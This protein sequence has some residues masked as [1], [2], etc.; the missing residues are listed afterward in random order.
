VRAVNLI[1]A[2]ERRG[3]G[4]LAGRSGGVV[5][6]VPGG[7]ALVVALGVVYA[8]AVHTVA[9]RTGELAAVNQQVAAVNAETA[10]LQ[11][12][13]QIASL[14]EQKL[15]QVATLAQQ[16]FNWP[17][18]MEQL[19]LALPN[20]VALT[21]LTAN[22]GTAAST[23]P[24][25]TAQAPV[26][27]GGASFALTGCANS[28]GEIPSILTDLSTVPG[29]SNVSLTSSAVSPAIRYH[30]LGTKLNHGGPVHASEPAAGTCPKVTWTLGLDYASSYTVP[31]VKLPQGSSSGA[32]TV[33]TASGTGSI[34]QTSSQV[35]R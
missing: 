3:A 32:Q 29:V 11:P 9:S 5:Y 14:S 31:K 18:A 33:S 17:A 30:G 21:A 12:Y 2:E 13:V 15:S 4:G 34:V 27:G 19:A 22:A 10:S 24:S 1:P 26:T 23:T 20:D 35:K 7:L 8:S 16:R 6:V 25:G 28:Q